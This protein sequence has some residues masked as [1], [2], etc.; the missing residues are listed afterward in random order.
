MKIRSTSVVIAAVISAAGATWIVAG[1]LNPPTGPV[2][3]GGATSQEIYDAV[4]G[5]SG[6]LGNAGARAP[7]VPGENS[8][9]GSFTIA[10]A[11]VVSGPMIGMRLSV[12]NPVIIG[13]S[14]SS[15]AVFDGVTIIRETGP[16]DAALYKALTTGQFA[17]TASITVPTSGGGDDVYALG[18]VAV[19]GIRSFQVQ[20]AD[21]SM[22]T[23]EEIDLISRDLRFTDSEGG[24]W[25]FNYSTNIG[26]G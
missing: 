20:R 3:A 10:Y 21:G 22:V 11:T 12:H 2:S 19:T 25:T 1:P 4:T 8:G 15:R 6:A 16:G 24:T 5:I 14:G 26:G 17:P 13:G 9:A 23:I 18:N 7:A